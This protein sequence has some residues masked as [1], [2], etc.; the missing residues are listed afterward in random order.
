MGPLGAITQHLKRVICTP[1]LDV[2]YE[3]QCYITVMMSTL[4]EHHAMSLQQGSLFTEGCMLV[5]HNGNV[6]ARYCAECISILTETVARP[7]A[8]AAR[9]CYHYYI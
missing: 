9:C 8:A 4:A 1:V 6:R 3:T 2:Q 5:Y 7:Y